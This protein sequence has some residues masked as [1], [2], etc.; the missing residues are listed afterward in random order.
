MADDGKKHG[1]L[2]DIV[3]AESMVQV[4]IAL[5]LACLIGWGLGTLLDRH[6]HTTWIMF[7]GI[8]LGAVAGFIQMYTTAARYLKRSGD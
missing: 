2:G 5:P 1:A 7:V 4:A 6:F 3:K 8:G